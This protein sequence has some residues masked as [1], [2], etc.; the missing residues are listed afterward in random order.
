MTGEL[1]EALA[2]DLA[3]VRVPTIELAE[4]L[5]GLAPLAVQGMK[6]ILRDV[7]AGTMDEAAARALIE[8]CASSRD[9][10]EGVR[11]RREGCTPRFQGR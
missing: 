3:T 8:A 7:A 10:R 11:A 4:R 6:R 2:D 5:A 1:F 9:F